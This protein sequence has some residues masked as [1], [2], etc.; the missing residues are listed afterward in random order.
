MNFGSKTIEI[1]IGKDGSIDSVT[2]TKQSDQKHN[3]K[4]KKEIRKEVRKKSKEPGIGNRVYD[5]DI[6]G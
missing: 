3:K 6:K 4:K 2:E 1:N 5:I